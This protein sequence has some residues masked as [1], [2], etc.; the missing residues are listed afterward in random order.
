METGRKKTILSMLAALLLAGLAVYLLAQKPA[1]PQAAFVTLNGEKIEL[2]SLRGKVVL[3]NFWA[4]S[5]PGCIAEMPELVKTHKKFEARGLETIA[6][7]MR[8]DPPEYV[9]RFSENNNL[10]FKVALDKDGSAAQAFG[11]RVTPTTFVIDK[12]GQIA[13]RIVGEPDFA[14]LHTLIEQTL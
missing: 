14:K 7:A 10:P 12:Q 8:Y 5:C 3:V 11:A 6:V 4:T 13:Q 2:G 9:K 1:A